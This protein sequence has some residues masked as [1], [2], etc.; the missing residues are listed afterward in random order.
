M[1]QASPTIATKALHLIL[2]NAGQICGKR[3]SP[4]LY[5][6]NPGCQVSWET[7][8]MSRERPRHWGWERMGMGDGMQ[9]H[10]QLPP[11]VHRMIPVHETSK[12]KGHERRQSP[13]ATEFSQ[14]VHLYH[15]YSRLGRAPYNPH[16]HGGVGLQV[17]HCQGKPFGGKV[18]TRFRF[19]ATQLPKGECRVRD[20]N[21]LSA[22]GW[23]WVARLL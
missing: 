3:G 2:P 19:G 21:H 9:M 7:Q 6:D 5:L 12:A 13:S 22:G 23:E 4:S 11:S 18:M 20:N 1:F 15:W 14:V 16:A 8:V 17:F 10:D